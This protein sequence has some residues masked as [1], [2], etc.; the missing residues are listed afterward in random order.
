MPNIVLVGCHSVEMCDD[1]ARTIATLGIDPIEAVITFSPEIVC[2]NAATSKDS[3]YLVVRDT[4]KNT[5]M[6]IALA[7]NKGLN[8]DVEIE[9]IAGFLPCKGKP[10]S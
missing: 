7:L 2:F 3:P 6:N 8:V 9:V 1:I 4:E 5:A 10:F